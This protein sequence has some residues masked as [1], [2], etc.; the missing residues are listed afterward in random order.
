MELQHLTTLHEPTP[1][2]IDPGCAPYFGWQLRSETPAPAR[3]PTAC[4]SAGRTAR[5]CGTP[6]ASGAGRRPL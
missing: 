6:A 3:P 4:R 1:L 2:G 5:P